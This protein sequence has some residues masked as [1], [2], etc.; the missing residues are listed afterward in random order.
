MNF[1]NLR[2]WA[3][4]SACT[5]VLFASCSGVVLRSGSGRKVGPPP[6]A[7]AHGCRRKLPKG[8]EVVYDSGSG[9]YVVVGFE[10][11]YYLDGH[12]YR[13][14]SNRWE[15]SMQVDVGWEPARIELVPAKLRGKYKA[16]HIS[17][18]HPG[19]GYGLQG[20]NKWQ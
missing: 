6:H 18:T 20:K 17:K 11:H 8:V 3:A 13:F 15:I 5:V 4:V 10:K 2:W 19:R 9:V 12:Y 14:C 7:P 16:K 1:R